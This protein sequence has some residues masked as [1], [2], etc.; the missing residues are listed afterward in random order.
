MMAIVGKDMGFSFSGSCAC[1]ANTV[2]TRSGKYERAARLLFSAWTLPPGTPHTTAY[3]NALGTV[4][5]W[6]LGGEAGR[7]AA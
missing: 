4:H 7:V 3:G 5:H 2:T 6:W 1:Y